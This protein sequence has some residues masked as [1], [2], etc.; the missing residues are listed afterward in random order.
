M[1][2]ISNLG[3]LGMVQLGLKHQCCLASMTM[4]IQIII[5]LQSQLHNLI[6]SLNR[7][8]LSSP[9]IADNF[10]LRV[11]KLPCQGLGKGSNVV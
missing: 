10:K 5:S 2:H 1:Q 8:S 7:R 11:M 6:I 9:V 4:F 3:I